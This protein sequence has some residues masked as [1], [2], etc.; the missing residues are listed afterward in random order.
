MRTQV[1]CFIRFIQ[2][3]QTDGQT[4]SDN[5]NYYYYYYYFYVAPINNYRDRNIIT[6]IK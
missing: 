3:Y 2:K 4:A 6:R 5:N 1:I